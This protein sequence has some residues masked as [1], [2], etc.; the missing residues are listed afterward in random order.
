MVK[1]F[2][3]GLATL[4]LLASLFVWPT[5]S[6]AATHQQTTVTKQNVVPST[7]GGWESLGGVLPGDEAPTVISWGPNRIDVFARGT[8]YTLWHK[9]R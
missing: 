7:W 9:W 5:V 1:K 4:L 3:G 8:D 6:L 2:F